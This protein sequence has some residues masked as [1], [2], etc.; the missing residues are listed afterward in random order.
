MA[1]LLITRHGQT[2][3]NVDR[4]I[5]GKKHG[6]VTDEGFK[7]ITKLISRLKDEKIM[8]IISSDIPRCRITAEQ[9]SKEIPISIEYLSLIREKDNGDWVGKSHSNIDWDSLQ[10]AFETRKAPNGEN[11]ME[12]LERGQKFIT[13]IFERFKDENSTILVISHGAFLKVLIGH[14][15]GMSI[16]DS[17]FK[18][19]IDHCSLTE[20]EFNKN[21]EK[22]YR[23]NY[24]NET[25]HLK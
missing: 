1:R 20:I 9:I 3:E 15:L 23:L 24:I 6:N 2:K 10:G 13:Q 17:I 4:I 7:Q 18:L 25:N 5:Q 14:L 19:F 8:K 21:Y 22:G 12:V 11:L 16:S